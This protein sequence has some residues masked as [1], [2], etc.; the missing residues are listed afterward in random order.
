MKKSL[1][2][3]FTLVELI[4]VIAIIA[5]LSTVAFVGYNMF[6]DEANISADQQEL[7]NMND[8]LSLTLVEKKLSAID[9]DYDDI[10]YILTDIS[11]QISFRP[12]YKYGVYYFDKSTN[13]IEYSRDGIEPLK[14]G[15][16]N[17]GNST[18]EDL[19]GT[20]KIFLNET[21]MFADWVRDF[22]NIKNQNMYDALRE[23][24]MELGLVSVYEAFKPETTLFISASNAFNAGGEIERVIFERN[25]KAIFDP[26]IY[27]KY[28]LAEGVK[29]TIPRSVRYIGPNAFGYL[30]GDIEIN[31]KDRNNTLVL[32]SSLGVNVK[33]NAKKVDASVLAAQNE[34][35]NTLIS[36]A[37]LE[38]LDKS[39]IDVNVDASGALFIDLT[40][41]DAEMK[42]NLAPFQAANPDITGFVADI[43]S[44]GDSVRIVSFMA[45][46]NEGIIA[47]VKI[48]VKVVTN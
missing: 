2:K 7:K 4:V 11:D 8:L 18:F 31:V 29:I 48:K 20:G 43:S 24:A 32:H 5:I 37:I 12:R 38:E 40:E 47:F 17:F 34:A 42:L 45:F 16:V 6:I 19:F 25:I 23:R 46:N 30:L 3:A 26:N 33:S 1:K 9:L 10:A 36:D 39:R 28:T 13:K 35:N 22:R 15:V 41:V 14:S 44:A 27:E 21:G